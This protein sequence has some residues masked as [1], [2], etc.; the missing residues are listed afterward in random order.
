MGIT[1]RRLGVED[2]D[3]LAAL[4]ARIEGDHPTGFC[5]GAGE[6]RELMEGK[7]DNVF[8][9]A[10]DGDRMVAY[11]STLPGRPDDTGLRIILFG[12]ADPARLGEGLGTLMLTRSLDRSRAIHADIAP[13]VPGTFV[14]TAL[15]GREDQA[16]L[17]ARA[18]MRAGRHSFLM[19]APLEPRAEAT[20]P[21][22]YAVTAFDPLAAEELRQAHNAAFAGYPDRPDASPEFWAMFVVGAAHARHAL[23]VVARDAGG[24][25][26]AYALAHEYVVPPSGGPGP[27][28]HVAYVGTLP[29]HR[30]RGLATGL[31][32]EVLRRASAAGY[33]RASLHVDTANPTGALGVYERAGFRPRYR[34]DS[35]VRDEPPPGDHLSR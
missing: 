23:S 20:T 34:Q 26:A 6:I 16:D 14:T 28:I 3:A 9:G 35:Y 33:V 1:T 10:F 12:D 2:A 31:L 8:E 27:E 29:A 4:M 25:V 18:G 5:L 7:A 21:V 22:G 11:T 19:V 24:S 32:A 30:G 15:A 13:R 17:M